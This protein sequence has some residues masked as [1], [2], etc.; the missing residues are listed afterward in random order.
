[1]S[2]LELAPKLGVDALTIE[3]VLRALVSM[4]VCDEIDSSRYQLT[5]LGEY[6]RPSHPDS[7][8][9]RVLLNGKNYNVIEA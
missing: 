7:I 5:S 6:L 8:E 4:K 9:A 2:A 3:R 1:M